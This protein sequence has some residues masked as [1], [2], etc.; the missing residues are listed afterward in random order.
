M[1]TAEILHR[2]REKSLVMRQRCGLLRADAPPLANINVDAPTWIQPDTTL[3]SQPYV[4]AARRILDGEYPIFAL[5]P[6][7]L[8]AVPQ[9]NTDP[10]SG[11]RAPLG[12]GRSINYRDA[13]I[14]GDIKYLWEPNRHRQWVVLAQAY[15]LSGDSDILNGLGKQL[16]A[17]LDQ[18]PYPLGANWTSSLEL[19]IRLINWSIVW[20]LIGGVQ[21]PLFS[22]EQGEHLRKRWLDSIYQHCHD[23]NL[24]WSRH[25]SANNHLIGEAAGLYIATVTWPYWERS[26]QWQETSQ[27]ILAEEAV[28]QNTRDG[29][30]REQ[31][32]SYQQFVLDFLLFAGLAARGSRQDFPPGYWRTIE[33]MLEFLNAIMD[34]RGN[35]PMI[36]DA[37]DGF[38]SDLAPGEQSFCPYKSL[39]A[40]GAVL[41]AR[42]DFLRKADGIDHKTRWLL[43]DIDAR[44]NKLDHSQRAPAPRQFME[45]GYYIIGR[46]LDTEQEVR[47]TV[48]VG[49][50]GYLGIAAHGHA[51]ALSFTLT[52]RGTEILIDPGTYAYHTNKKWRDYFR[53]TSAHNTIRVDGQDQSKPGGNFMWLAKAEA[54]CETWEPDAVPQRLVASHDGYE[55]LTDPV[56]HRRE[57]VFDSDNDT[58]DINDY[59]ECSG[60]HSIERLWHFSEN[61]DVSTTDNGLR[62]ETETGTTVFEFNP[63]ENR[64]IILY[65]GSEE[66]VSGW[67]SRAYDSKEPI[68]TAVETLHVSGTIKLSATLKL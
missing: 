7:R 57:F 61:C 66:P 9:W 4:D 12:F 43:R 2:L 47:C 65:R 33:S 26:S 59:I 62:V 41:F 8:G 3:P 23:I 6:A 13:S 39:L 60:S 52:V 44:L 28:T 16:N 37:D 42:P 24:Y 50:L 67:I 36:G 45:G 55:R 27:A 48:D 31:A 25:S 49:P 30:N 58:L 46:D 40:T 63:V 68:T 35:V 15:A 54:T 14:V 34:P 32:I 20:Q 22:G 17:W 56:R 38:V 51:D 18:C 29:V 19:G 11:T 64:E 53:G 10:K 21:S 1:P 5:R